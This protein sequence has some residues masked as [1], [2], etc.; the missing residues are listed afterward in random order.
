VGDFTLEGPFRIFLIFVELQL[1]HD[2]ISLFI[3][4]KNMYFQILN[5]HATKMI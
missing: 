2:H 3:C 4:T 5:R 1:M